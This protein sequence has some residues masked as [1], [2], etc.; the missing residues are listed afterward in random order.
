MFVSRNAGLFA[1]S[2]PKKPTAPT[3]L[4]ATNSKI[5]K[6]SLSWNAP[7]NTG[8]PVVTGYTVEVV[9]VT[10]VSLGNV[11][12]YEW[13]GGTKG[14]Q[15]AFK[16]YAN[17]AAGQS[18][19]SNATSPITL[20]GV[21]ATGGTVTTYTSGGNL[22]KVHSFTT[23]GSNTLTV[24]NSGLVD[25]LVVAGGQ[26]GGSDFSRYGGN[27]GGYSAGTSTLSVTSYAMTVGYGGAGYTNPPTLGGPSVFNGI[28]VNSGAGASGGAPYPN[29][30]P[31]QGYGGGTGLANSIQ[32]GSTQ[33]Y[34]SGGG[35]GG[36]INGS[37]GP[38]GP[39]Y[40]GLG[41]GGAC[42]SGT[43]GGWGGNQ[44]IVIVRYVEL[45]A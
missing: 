43:C 27:G 33:Y 45:E 24:T 21:S 42:W 38:A 44:G 26:A 16:V 31:G 7:I 29:P 19:A 4:A 18:G 14:T 41:G 1:S 25:Y 22:Y 13:T 28:T 30:D 36:G 2:M 8:Y 20:N 6:I 23:V 39:G 11:T 10:T 32:T 12:S 34:G 15:Y 35:G 9:G 5:G 3:S 37:V 40:Y 17:N